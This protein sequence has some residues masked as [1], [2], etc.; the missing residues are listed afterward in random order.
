MVG[1]YLADFGDQD[2]PGDTAQVAHTVGTDASVLGPDLNDPQGLL[3]VLSLLAR[4]LDNHKVVLSSDQ[5]SPTL[6]V[7]YGAEQVQTN[8]LFDVARHC[9][10]LQLAKTDIDLDL[11]VLKG[12]DGHLGVD[13][14]RQVPYFA[15]GQQTIGELVEEVGFPLYEV[16]T[17]A[18]QIDVTA[19]GAQVQDVAPEGQEFSSVLINFVLVDSHLIL[20][21][22]YAPLLHNVTDELHGLVLEYLL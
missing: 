13:P 15:P 21:D 20:G 11:F 18:N 7:L 1:E 10:C 9:L 22:L 3:E 4:E 14:G 19:V 12:D 2:G 17:D 6:F 16:G 8:H 5:G